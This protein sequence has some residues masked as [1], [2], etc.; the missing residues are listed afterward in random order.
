MLHHF[1]P[2][3][4][5]ILTTPPSDI[6]KAR[7]HVLQVRSDEARDTESSSKGQSSLSRWSA[8]ASA[9]SSS[10]SSTGYGSGSSISSDED[11]IL[12][13]DAGLRKGRV[14]LPSWTVTELAGQVER[15]GQASAGKKPVV[16]FLE[17]YAVDVTEYASS[18]PG[19]M[20]VLM[21]HAVKSPEGGVEGVVVDS[22]AAFGG[23]LNN[24]GWSANEKMRSM[25][26]ARVTGF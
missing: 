2:F 17:G 25:R 3:V 20:A 12:D 15:H 8:Y 11:S 22:T 24:H 23:G 21:R 26:I 5:R 19:G 10:E 6:L 1:T 13:D 14:G 7:A 18:H 9:T 16:L 4:P